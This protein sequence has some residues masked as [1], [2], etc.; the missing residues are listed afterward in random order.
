VTYSVVS[1][2]DRKVKIQL[3]KQVSAAFEPG[4][5]SALMGASGSGKT[6]L[7]GA[8]RSLSLRLARCKR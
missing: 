3:L 1:R 4:K 7:L 6:T 2:K 8:L 5:M